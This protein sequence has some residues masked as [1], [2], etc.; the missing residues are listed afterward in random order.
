M[1][2]APRQAGQ[3]VP[4]FCGR[5]SQYDA[6]N[7]V[8]LEESRSYDQALRIIHPSSKEGHM[9]GMRIIEQ[10]SM[11]IFAGKGLCHWKDHLRESRA[12]NNYNSRG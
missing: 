4:P 12:C 2:D 9:S 10:S 1:L 3:F 7:K 6:D 8:V 11:H 5:S